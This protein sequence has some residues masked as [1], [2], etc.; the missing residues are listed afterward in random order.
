MES[1]GCP[2]AAGEYPVGD[3]TDTMLGTGVDLITQC[4]IEEKT[5]SGTHQVRAARLVE[6]KTGSANCWTDA[7]GVMLGVLRDF[8]CSPANMAM[9]QLA[10]T[11]AIFRRSG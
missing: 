1:K 8:P 4:V 10:L 3:I 11:C 9:V 7:Q 2:P 6:I 5:E